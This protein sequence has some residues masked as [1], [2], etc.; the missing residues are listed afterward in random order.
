[1]P[2]E[3]SASPHPDSALGL[4]RPP[5]AGTAL[6]DT[7]GA[8]VIGVLLRSFAERMILGM[9]LLKEPELATR[10]LVGAHARNVGSLVD[11][12]NLIG[13]GDPPAV[14][15]AQALYVTDEESRLD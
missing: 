15:A 5:R 7:G 2:A 8:A 6:T 3:P 10:K 14:A 11:R 12:N 4:R 13:L 9:W 1:M